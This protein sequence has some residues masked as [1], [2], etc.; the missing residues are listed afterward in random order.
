LNRPERLGC[1]ALG[2]GAAIVGV[3]VTVAAVIVV[4]RARAPGE[5]TDDPAR[6]F[7][8][9]WAPC[10]GTSSPSD[11]IDAPLS[12][13]DPKR[14]DVAEVFG[15]ARA[16]ALRLEPSAR[17]TSISATGL[18]RE[19]RYDLT[20][21]N[22]SIHFEYR[23]LDATKPPGADRRQG[24]AFVLLSGKH[25]RAQR[26]DLSVGLLDF[27]PPLSDPPCGTA[28]AWRAVVASGV[29]DDARATFVLS[30]WKEGGGGRHAPPPRDIT[31]WIVDV[32]GH[33]DLRREVEAGACRVTR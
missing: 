32:P 26:V 22:M 15:Q 23:C 6:P 20:T 5:T 24:Q 7:V 25:A 31:V 13:A 3:V 2:C 16:L 27:A 1:I 8:P 9:S 4:N 14:V 10:A 17:L 28:A 30:P 18:A 19:G 21:A 33:P 29:P 11:S 12:V